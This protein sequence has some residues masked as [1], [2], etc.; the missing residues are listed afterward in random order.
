MFSALRRVVPLGSRRFS[1]AAFQYE[2]LFQ[3]SGALPHAFRKLTSDYVS[4]FEVQGKQAQRPPPRGAATA[5]PSRARLFL[6]ADAGHRAGGA[7]A[8]A[9]TPLRQP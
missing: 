2:E 1:A 9:G 5:A 3:Q 4:T 6:R 8:D 7:A